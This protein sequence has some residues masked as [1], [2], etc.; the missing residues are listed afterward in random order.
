MLG[1]EVFAINDSIEGNSIN[2][3][4]GSEY[5]REHPQ[6]L[7]DAMQQHGASYGF[8]FDGDGDRLV[9]VDRKGR[10]FDG[11]DLLFILATH[12]HSKG[13][14]KGN[15]VVTN[16]LANRG[17]E[18]ALRCVGIQTKYTRKG[19]RNLETAMWGS[20]Y[21]LGG[22][23]VGNII[24]N[25]G[26]HTAADAVYTAIVLSGML[27]QDPD[28]GLSDRVAQLEKRPQVTISFKLSATPTLE[29]RAVF[30]EE[31]RRRQE[32][33]GDG[34]RILIWDSSTEPGVFRVMIEGGPKNT[35]EQILKAAEDL[36]CLIQQVSGSTD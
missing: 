23:P 6:E 30:Q 17:L 9:V 19:D 3:C 16:D 32:A 35:R 2:H 14:F 18:D 27:V 12:L 24:I 34:S 15:A 25:D 33:L 26:H 1:A 8:A 31:I 13:R 11:E 28:V 36:S 29:H 7:V 21:V 4:R 5:V 20:G 22:E 10:V